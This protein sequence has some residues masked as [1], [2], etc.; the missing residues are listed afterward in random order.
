MIRK[1]RHVGIVTNDIN[2]MMAFYISLG[3]TPKKGS[4]EN[5]KKYFG[6][7]ITVITQK[8]EAIDGTI[9][10][11]LS[12]SQLA[13]HT[14]SN[15]FFD[16]GISHIAFTVT[17]IKM[18][19]DKLKKQGGTIFTKEMVMDKEGRKIVFCQDIEG[20]ILELVEE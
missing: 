11:L 8:I 7:D 6:E 3:F 18:V 4:I 17:D 2:K 14:G 15:N 1:I 13:K 10:E 9:L 19:C 12:F 5:M 20:N 16:N